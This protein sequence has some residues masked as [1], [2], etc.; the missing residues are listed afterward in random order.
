MQTNNSTLLWLTNRGSASKLLVRWWQQIWTGDQYR[1]QGHSEHSCVWTISVGH[2]RNRDGAI[3]YIQ[4]YW[5]KFRI[6]VVYVIGRTSIS[7]LYVMKIELTRIDWLNIYVIV[8]SIINCKYTNQ[9]SSVDCVVGINIIMLLIHDK[10]FF[11]NDSTRV[12][13]TCTFKQKLVDVVAI[14]SSK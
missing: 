8:F 1:N 14:Y 13:Y 9:W 12:E 4:L 10:D 5:T 3:T 11:L 2:N 6:P 7:F